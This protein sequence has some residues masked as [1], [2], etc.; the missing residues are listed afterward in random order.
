M[1]S[2]ERI[3]QGNVVDVTTGRIFPGSVVIREGKIAE[4]R[5]E[6][7]SATN[8]ILPGLIDAHIHVESSMLIPSEFARLAVVHGTTAT[9]SDPHEIANVLGIG[10]V[11]FMIANGKKVPF[12]FYFGAPSCVPATPFETA[13]ASITPADIRELLAMPEVRYLS[14]MMNF[15]GVLYGDAEVMEKLRLAKEA[16][17]PVDGHAPGVNGE[18]A[19]KYIA[20]GISTDHECFTLEEARD[21]ISHGMHILIREGSAARNFEALWPLIDEFPDKVM[22]CSDDKHPD[23]LAAGHINRLLKRAAELGIDR[24]NAIRA[25]T[26]NPVVHYNL[27]AGLLSPGDPADLAVVDNLTEF[28]VLATYVNGVKVAE[29]G[30][31]LIPHTEEVALNNFNIGPI[32]QDEINVAPEGD[33]LKVMGALEGQLITETGY[34]QPLVRDGNVI[35]DPARDIL[36]IVVKNRYSESPAA[37]GFIRNFGFKAG[38]IASSVAHD[39]HNIV[40]VG[41]DDRSI[42]EAINLV[43][44][45]KGGVAVTGPEG[46]EVLPLPVAGIMSAGDGYEVARQYHELDQAVKKMGC[47]LSAPF[48]TL[49]FMALLVIPELKLSDKGL[50]DGTRFAFTSVFGK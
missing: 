1:S 2:T 14:E 50:F 27:D 13:G 25:C 7:V 36:K 19:A 6:Q 38:A 42:T 30:K 17:K 3:I 10:G 37:V 23:D 9:V 15:P 5:E 34:A 35:S 8:F 44:G 12:R 24:M 33:L 28:N 31:S 22:L 20:A 4:I 46:Y 18:A 41:A 47:T 45:C 39:S 16:G 40:A 21:K 48:M 29:G 11:R 49:S 43:I 32:T 26:L